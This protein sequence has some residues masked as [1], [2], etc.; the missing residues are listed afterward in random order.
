MNRRYVTVN[1]VKRG[2]VKNGQYF[3]F[4]T[5]LITRRWMGNACYCPYIDVLDSRGDV[6]A[7]YV[8]DDCK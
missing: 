4:P 7:A 3:P 8:K 2:Y 5:N 6:S 1:D